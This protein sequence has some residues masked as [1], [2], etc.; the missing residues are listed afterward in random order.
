MKHDGRS[1]TIDCSFCRL[2]SNHNTQCD[3]NKAEIGMGTKGDDLHEA[4]Q[5]FEL[6]SIAATCKT[7]ISDQGPPSMN[8]RYGKAVP[9]ERTVIAAPLRLPMF[10][11]PLLC[12]IFAKLSV[13]ANKQREYVICQGIRGSNL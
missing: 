10:G 2:F 12:L 11:P 13:P 6:D 4:R 7:K 8:V 1:H 5:P 3:N 9:L